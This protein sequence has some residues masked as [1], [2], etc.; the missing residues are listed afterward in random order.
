MPQNNVVFTVVDCLLK[1]P[2]QIRILSRLPP[3]PA[4]LNSL[5][6]PTLNMQAQ[7]PPILHGVMREGRRP[8]S[9]TGFGLL[10]PQ[11]GTASPP[12]RNPMITPQFATYKVGSGGRYAAEARAGDFLP[13]ALLTLV[14]CCSIISFYGRPR[15]NT[16][17]GRIHL[18][19]SIPDSIPVVRGVKCCLWRQQRLRPCRIHRPYPH[20]RP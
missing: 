2:S 10:R 12:K 4:A 17:Q 14:M 1:E 3:L 11:V 16:R 13:N 20:L 18:R 7:R 8:L 6:S 19:H 5:L 9:A 15:T